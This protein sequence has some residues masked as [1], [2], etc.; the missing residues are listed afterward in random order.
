MSLLP[1]CWSFFPRA[2][3]EIREPSSRSLQDDR[4]GDEAARITHFDKACKAHEPLDVCRREHGPTHLGS[5]DLARH[6]GV[7][8]RVKSQKSWY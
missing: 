4:N 7:D 6:T 2:C 1:T 8:T 5:R 3:S